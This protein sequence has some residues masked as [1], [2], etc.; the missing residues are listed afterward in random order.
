M[1]FLAFQNADA[2]HSLGY[3]K[4]TRAHRHR[5]IYAQQ[6]GVCIKTTYYEIIR[7]C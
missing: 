2:I 5:H 7:S 6:N 1:E 4:N 3:S